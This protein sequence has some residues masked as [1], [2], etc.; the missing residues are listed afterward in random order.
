MP[1]TIWKLWGFDT[2]AREKYL[3]GEFASEDEAQQRKRQLESEVAS[4]QSQDLRDS[5][6]I[7]SPIENE[8]S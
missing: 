3:V 5:F 2:F 6:W 1:T 7:E 4:S 8:R